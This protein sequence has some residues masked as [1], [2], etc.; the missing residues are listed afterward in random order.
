MLGGSDG[1]GWVVGGGR[2]GWGW[3]GFCGWLVGG[4]VTG[5][6]VV[7][8]FST[9]PPSSAGGTN[10]AFSRL[11]VATSMKSCQIWAGTVPPET[12]RS[13]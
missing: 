11:R 8:G 7:V 9:T 10:G 1:P 12:P 5:G 13:P 4:A 3:P 2:V 6:A